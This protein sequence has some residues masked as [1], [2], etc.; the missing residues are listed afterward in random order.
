MTPSSRENFGLPSR[1]PFVESVLLSSQSVET[2]SNSSSSGIKLML[3]LEGLLEK[4]LH[5]GSGVKGEHREAGLASEMGIVVNR[6]S[7][8]GKW[9]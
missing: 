5:R 4:G 8:L 7:R 3:S 9:R 6:K 1:P 2:Y